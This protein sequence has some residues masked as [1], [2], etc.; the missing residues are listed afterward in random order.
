M[1]DESDT[2]EGN[3]LMLMKSQTPLFWSVGL[4]G[5]RIDHL[6][7]NPFIISKNIPNLTIIDE[8]Q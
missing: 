5:N 3:R 1:K 8:P 6:Y 7:A 2:F 4:Q